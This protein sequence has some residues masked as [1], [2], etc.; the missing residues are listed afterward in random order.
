[1]DQLPPET[2]PTGTHGFGIPEAV[3]LGHALHRCPNN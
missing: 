1:M 3:A 2:G